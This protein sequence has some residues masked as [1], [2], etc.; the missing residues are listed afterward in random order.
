M[1]PFSVRAKREAAVW[2]AVAAVCD[3]ELDEPVTEM[4]FV[5][6]IE[7]GEDGLV[8]LD[9]RLPTYW[10]SP[11]F[12]FLMLDGVRRAVEALPWRPR[13]RITLHDH[14]FAEQ[15]NQG[16]AAG[17]RFQ[18]IFEELAPGENL[19]ALALKFQMKAFQR[20][21]EALLGSLREAGWSP[22]E[23]LALDR[24]SLDD[25]PKALSAVFVRYAEAFAARFPKA[26]GGDPVIVDWDGVAVDV[27]GFA[28]HLAR[29]RLVRINM[30][31]NGALCRGLKEVRYREKADGELTLV[32]FLPRP[33]LACA[34]AG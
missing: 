31:F 18:D 3:P 15:V 16:V 11:N 27:A 12:A 4:G 30:E 20:R 28:E 8:R 32:D 29:L 7:V 24:S 34:A 2:D 14:L 9:F 22:S 6:R 5:E 19:D 21:Q 26:E 1:Q 13:H 33:T 25:P 10:C 23:M 17:R